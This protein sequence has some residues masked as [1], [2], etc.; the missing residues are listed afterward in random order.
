MGILML[1]SVMLIALSGVHYFEDNEVITLKTLITLS[2]VMITIS[3]IGYIIVR[4]QNSAEYFEVNIWINI[5]LLAIH[6]L[7][8][9]RKGIIKRKK[10][11]KEI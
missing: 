11:N 9:T 3:T 1:S 8:T 2:C 6:S 10:A 7:H 4:G 5:V